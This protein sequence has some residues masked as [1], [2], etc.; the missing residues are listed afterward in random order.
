MLNTTFNDYD[1]IYTVLESTA[2]FIIGV[3]KQ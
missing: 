2:I 3:D 1:I